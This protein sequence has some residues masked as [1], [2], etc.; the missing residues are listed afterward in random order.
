MVEHLKGKAGH[1]KDNFS[2]PLSIELEFEE[3]LCVHCKRT[4][5]NGIRCLGICVS[6]NDY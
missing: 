1:N 4:K 5:D 6:E 3:V 2:K